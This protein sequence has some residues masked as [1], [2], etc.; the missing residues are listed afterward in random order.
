MEP[1]EDEEGVVHGFRVVDIEFISSAFDQ[2]PAQP[3]APAPAAP[4]QREQAGRKREPGEEPAP[5]PFPKMWKGAD[6]AG[7]P[8][9]CK[10]C[11]KGFKWKKDLV[12]HGP[13]HTGERPFPCNICNKA[14][15]EKSTLTRH[16]AEVHAGVKRKKRPLRHDCYV[17]GKGFPWPAALVIHSRVHSGVR[18]FPCYFC[19]WAFKTKGGLTSHMFTH[20]GGR[21]RPHECWV[22]VRPFSKRCH[23]AVHMRKHT[24]ERPFPCTHCGRKFATCSQLYRHRR[25]LHGLDK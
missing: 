17:C 13:V 20:T 3:P 22:C 6:G 15:K 14:F 4:K 5:S 16:V 10:F 24:G 18:P 21:P 8:H 23:L 11:G 12:K 7:R 1:D 19:K 2:G 25:R 9:V